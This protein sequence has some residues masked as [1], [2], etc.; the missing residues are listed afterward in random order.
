MCTF[1][2]SDVFNLIYLSVVHIRN[3]WIFGLCPKSDILKTLENPMI[4]Q[5]MLMLIEFQRHI[6][7]ISPT[8]NK[9]RRYIWKYA[10]HNGYDGS[11]YKD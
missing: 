1:H 2:V 5:P 7:Q 9:K 3:D 4:G 11:S 8:Q 10:G 6:V